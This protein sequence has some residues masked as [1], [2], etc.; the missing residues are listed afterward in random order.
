MTKLRVLVFAAM[1][2]VSSA[3]SAYA[4]PRADAIAAMQPRIDAT[5][6]AAEEKL[7]NI[8]PET[9]AVPQDIIRARAADL[10]SRAFAA[11]RTAKQQCMNTCRA[12]YRDC[13]HLNQLSSSECRGIYRDCTRYSCAGLGPG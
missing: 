1:A 11:A 2:V 7:G 8:S 13:R 4:A 10:A 9:V 5:L 3:L 12:R 6:A